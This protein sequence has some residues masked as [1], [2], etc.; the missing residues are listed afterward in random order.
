RPPHG[1]RPAACRDSL[2]RTLPGRSPAGPP[3]G[4]TRRGRAPAARAATGSRAGVDQALW[5]SSPANLT[6]VRKVVKLADSVVRGEMPGQIGCHGKTAPGSFRF[7]V[8]GE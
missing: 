2:P 6:L 1:A 8:S 7:F 3:L 4:H 5:A